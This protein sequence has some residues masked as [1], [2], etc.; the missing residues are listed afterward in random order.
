MAPTQT[1]YAKCVTREGESKREGNLVAC[2]DSIH[3]QLY[4]HACVRIYS[5]TYWDAY[6]KVCN[7]SWKLEQSQA[8]KRQVDH[9]LTWKLTSEREG[10]RKDRGSVEMLCLVIHVSSVWF[11]P[12]EPV[13][14][15][16]CL[17][18]SW[19]LGW[20]HVSSGQF[21]P[22]EPARTTEWVRESSKEDGFTRVKTGDGKLCLGDDLEKTTQDTCSFS[23]LDWGREKFCELWHLVFWNTQSHSIHTC[24]CESCQRLEGRKPALE[25]AMGEFV[26]IYWSTVQQ[27]VNTSGCKGQTFNHNS[28]F[29]WCHLSWQVV[30]VWINWVLTN[31]V[32]PVFILWICLHR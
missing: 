2:S 19:P 18:E 27:R 1:T 11:N 29:N 28:W 21:N 6:N 4:V 8:Q 22:F 13:W 23:E 5:I 30:C 20:F 3:W 15:T 26:Q 32:H 16:V 9:S 25:R 24:F 10:E 17:R 7:L 31:F 12:V 14:A